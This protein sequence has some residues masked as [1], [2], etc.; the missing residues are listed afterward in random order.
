MGGIYFGWSGVRFWA[1]A[2]SV[3]NWKYANFVRLLGE[4][5][6][7]KRG[8]CGLCPEF[9][10]YTLAFALQLW[11]NQEKTVRVSESCSGK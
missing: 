6:A 9:A 4:A 8:E 11:K 3:T 10:L 2:G 1:Q 7:P 5:A